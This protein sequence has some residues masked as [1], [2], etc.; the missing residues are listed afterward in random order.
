MRI[1]KKQKTVLELSGLLIF[2]TAY[3]SKNKYRRS[4]TERFYSIEHLTTG[5]LRE[6][7]ST[8][9]PHGW[10]DAEYYRLMPEGVKPPELTDGEIIM[11]IDADNKHNYFVVMVHCEG[12]ED[13]IMIGFE[14][15]YHPDFAIYLH[16]PLSLLD[17]L[18]EKYALTAK[19]EVKDYTINEFLIEEE[20]RKPLN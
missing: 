3:A 8:Y 4:M 9:I 18:V 6:L 12:E 15:A 10:N 2:D 13:G 14:M 19:E 17:E 5:Q 16:L 20:L 7:Y 11:G 1:K